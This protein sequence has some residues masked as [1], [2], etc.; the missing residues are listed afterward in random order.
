MSTFN[1]MPA[2][3]YNITEL[4]SNQKTGPIITTRHPQASCPV[5]CPFLGNGC[6]AE[7]FP[8]SKHW[9]NDL[10][11]GLNFETYLDRL[12]TLIRY[13]N[14]TGQTSM[15]RIGE[16]GDIGNG[17]TISPQAV[18]LAET[19][20]DSECVIWYSH[21]VPDAET[22]PVY[23]S[24][25]DRVCINVSADSPT[26]ADHYRD[27]GL[28]TVVVLPI[29]TPNVSWTPQGRKIVACPAEKANGRVTCLTCKLCGNKDRDY[30]IGFRAHGGRKKV[31]NRIVS[32]AV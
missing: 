3:G 5:T 22:L 30:I 2:T 24:I 14:L 28:P 13:R 26:M 9:R 11:K 23:R 12:V 18:H 29:G 15:I 10:E 8:L 7:N 32:V 17:V 19:I 21:Y 25:L 27:L 16:A 20:K 31:V 1:L 6:Y 4:S